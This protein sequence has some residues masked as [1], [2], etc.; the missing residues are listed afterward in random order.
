MKPEYI[1]DAAIILERAANMLNHN[2]APSKKCNCQ[3]K[4]RADTYRLCANLIRK[5]NGK[6]LP[7]L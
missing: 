1:E 4:V 2:H 3:S 5:I 7:L 6:Y